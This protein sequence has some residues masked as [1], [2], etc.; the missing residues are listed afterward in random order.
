MNANQIPYDAIDWLQIAIYF[1]ALPIIAFFGA[2][3]GLLGRW[4]GGGMLW[5]VNVGLLGGAAA[6]LTMSLPLRALNSDPHDNLF[7][8]YQH[9]YRWQMLGA[10]LGGAAGTALLAALA[11]RRM[12]PPTEVHSSTFSLKHLLIVQCLCVV[13]LGC[14][15]SLRH[16]IIEAS[17]SKKRVIRYWASK[18]WQLSD[19]LLSLNVASHVNTD[20]EIR[21]ALSAKHFSEMTTLLPN[22]RNISLPIE[23]TWNVELD[24]LFRHRGLRRI[25]LEVI[26]AK[27]NLLHGFKNS[28][29]EAL[30]LS[31]EIANVDLRPLCQSESLD[32]LLLVGKLRRDNIE[33]MRDANSLRVL[34]IEECRIT[35][36]ELPIQSWPRE[37]TELYVAKSNLDD[38]DFQ[39][40]LTHSRLHSLAI[41]DCFL[42][43]AT[44]R[45]ILEN[46]QLKLVKLTLFRPFDQLDELLASNASRR[47]MLDLR[48]PTLKQSQ[49]DSLARIPRL[50]GLDLT[51]LPHGDE[52]IA[53]VSKLNSLR[54]LVIAS[55]TVTREK[56][57]E[58]ARIK[59]LERL[60][61]PAL[62]LSA[63]FENE[64]HRI[65]KSLN[66][67]NLSVYGVAPPPTAPIGPTASNQQP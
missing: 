39:S 63:T 13:S 27:P 4:R 35:G 61:Y 54:Y 2:A 16:S 66:L 42:K 53:E 17:D 26:S 32:S 28:K 36:R 9:S 40:L 46:P 62:L 52:V 41:T 44:I 65:R 22:L 33:S 51:H 12:H 7:G 29:V 11:W 5:A 57:L 19:D 34:S 43:E 64:L 24:P 58:L 14:F 55:P 1:L 59:S 20:S 48:Y 47:V 37:M 18:D 23:H 38:R 30:F 10:A 3:I 50:E 56:V 21:K 8:I 60:G 49:L 31:G 15:I 25:V 67:P 6:C 45:S